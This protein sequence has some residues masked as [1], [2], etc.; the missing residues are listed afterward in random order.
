MARTNDKEYDCLLIYN[1][2]RSRLSRVEDNEL[3]LRVVEITDERLRQWGYT[4]NHYYD[5]DS[6]PGRNVFSELFR[7]VDSSQFVLIFLTRGFLTNCWIR[8]CQMAAF[9][10][11]IDESTRPDQIASHRFIPILINIT[12]DEVPQELGQLTHICFRDDW[13]MDG[14][15]W[16]KLKRALDGQSVQETRSG[17]IGDVRPPATPNHIGQCIPETCNEDPSVHSERRATQSRNFACNSSVASHN[18]NPEAVARNPISETEEA[19]LVK[20]PIH[21]NSFSSSELFASGGRELR[22]STSLS[23]TPQTDISLKQQSPLKPQ[24]A[25]SK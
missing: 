25:P 7:V 5:R 24:H 20:D 21:V 16:Q 10:K 4:K 1:H 17:G 15:E 23:I 18:V 9:K 11:L 8:Y 3:S 6:I 13:E 19:T 14:P 22:T 12:E 2:A